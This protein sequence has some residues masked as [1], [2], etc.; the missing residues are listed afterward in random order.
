MWFKKL[1]GFE[2]RT[3]EAVRAQLV[4]EGNSFRSKANGQRFQHGRLEIAS[5]ADLQ[6]QAAVLP[7]NPGRLRVQEI[8]ADVQALHCDPANARALFQA[9]SQFNLLEMV[10]PDVTPEQGVNG[11]EHDKTQG[12]A[13]AIACGAGTIYRNYLVPLGGQLGQSRH[14]QID[15]LAPI[16]EALGNQ[17]QRL[18]EM[19][20]GYALLQSQGLQEINALLEQMDEE[21][22]KALQGKLQIGLQW[23]TAVTLSAEEQIVSQAYCSAL[24]VAYSDI[25]AI[26]WAPFSSLILEATYLATLYAAQ[27]NLA[28]TGCN[29]VF[30]TLVGG[31]VFGNETAWIQQALQKAL[32][33]FR[34]LPL[35]V[36]IVSYGRSNPMVQAVCGV[37]G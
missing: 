15:C 30:L 17:Q 2:E 8:V 22:R 3:P 33:S 4:V 34:Q 20:N 14:R 9:A 32:Q 29:K 35:E 25:A 10:S 31:G 13:C 6:A 36:Y 5:L 26:H 27:I 23:D 19:R 28:T 18:W 16:G 12:P 1:L 37:F 11:Y 7:T 21:A 24:P